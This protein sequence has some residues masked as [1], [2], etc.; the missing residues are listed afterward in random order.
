MKNDATLSM[1]VVQVHEPESRSADVLSAAIDTQGFEYALLIVSCGTL[2]DTATLAVQV[3][4]ATASGGSYS[5]VS[6][7]LVSI[8]GSADDDSIFAG[9]IRLDGAER[10]L[11]VNGDYTGSGS[12]VYSTTVV[13]LNAVDSTDATTLTFSV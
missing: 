6:G 8:D 13:L 9:Q 1:K 7:A 3:S 12:V 2:A 5:D 10:Y 11:K 4:T